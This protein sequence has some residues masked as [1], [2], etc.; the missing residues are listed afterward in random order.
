MKPLRE[1]H[2]AADPDLAAAAHLLGQVGPLAHSRLTQRRVRYQLDSRHNRPVARGLRPAA[3]FGILCGFA[4]TAG[5][6]WGVLQATTSSDH[7][8]SVIDP[9]LVPRVGSGL[10]KGT[11]APA[12]RRSLAPVPSASEAPAPVVAPPALAPRTPSRPVAAKPSKPREAAAASEAALVHAAVKEL[13]GGGDPERARRLLEQYRTANPS[14]ELAEE[15]LVLSIEAAV[16]H[17]DPDAQRLARLY[18]AKY[19][20]GRFVA[21]ARR[22]I[23]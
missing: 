5:A 14:G 21:A 10:P 20:N 13:R 18:L 3:V 16:A 12:P 7:D 8:S 17:G 2:A 4:A 19:P 6:A 22:V 23:R 1:E 9:P 11:R 15:A